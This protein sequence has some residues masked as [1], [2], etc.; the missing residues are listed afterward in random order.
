MHSR[1]CERESGPSK[2]HRH[3]AGRAV[4]GVP[5]SRSAPPQLQFPRTLEQLSGCPCTVRMQSLDNLCCP[6]INNMEEPR[7]WCRAEGSGEAK[8]G[9]DAAVQMTELARHCGLAD[10]MRM[11]RLSGAVPY[12]TPML[13][14][15]SPCPRP[16]WCRSCWPTSLGRASRERYAAGHP[17]L[18][19]QPVC[20]RCQAVRRRDRLV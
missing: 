11:H 14:P 15:L 7:T 10:S 2:L 5:G 6:R 13:E 16:A 1:P 8:S 4:Q 17:K 20:T 18:R 19:A 3:P 12:L 9:R